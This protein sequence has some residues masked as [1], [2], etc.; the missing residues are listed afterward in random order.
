[1]RARV[2]TALFIVVLL[3]FLASGCA[4]LVGT[5]PPPSPHSL[6]GE[7]KN[8]R[9]CHEKGEQGAPVTDHATKPNCERCHQQTF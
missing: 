7:H 3:I 8:C 1:M 6:T 9:S 4:A 5:K 2:P